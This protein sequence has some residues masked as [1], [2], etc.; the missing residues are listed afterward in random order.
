MALPV[1]IHKKWKLSNNTIPS[2]SM[3]EALPFSRLLLS[4]QT[5]YINMLNQD[6]QELEIAQDELKSYSTPLYNLFDIEKPF[7]DLCYETIC[8]EKKEYENFEIAS[9]VSRSDVSRSDN[10]RCSSS[11]N[12]GDVDNDEAYYFYQ[13]ADGQY[14]K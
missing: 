10:T 9:D 12:M 8:K 1:E 7:Y 5:D 11:N 13:S 4:T 14:L 3:K 6:K 2:F